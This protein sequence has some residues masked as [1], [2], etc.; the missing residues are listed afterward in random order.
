MEINNE[1]IER[2]AKNARIKLSE[3]E[4]K[5]FVKDFDDI[6]KTFSIIS[7]VNT[8][9]VDPS[10]QPIEMRNILRDDKEEKCLSKDEALSNTEHKKDGFFKG[11]KVL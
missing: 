2:V 10:F 5:G 9:D 3:D 7:E 11:P 1:L 4:I 8:D 6:L